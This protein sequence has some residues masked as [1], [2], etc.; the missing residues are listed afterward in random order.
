M[1]YIRYVRIITTLTACEVGTV[2]VIIDAGH[3]CS[4]ASFQWMKQTTVGQAFSFQLK[5]Y[6]QCMVSW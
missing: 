1:H 5:G 2:T 3:H 4:L 6:I